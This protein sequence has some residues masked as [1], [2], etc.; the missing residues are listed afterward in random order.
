LYESMAVLTPY[1]NPRRGAVALERINAVLPPLY[2]TWALPLVLVAA[3]VTPSRP[4]A[5]SDTPAEPTSARTPLH[6]A[7]DSLAAIVFGCALI[8]FAIRARVGLT[9]LEFGDETQNY[10]AAVMIRHGLRLYKDILLNH[11]PLED[12]LA[13]L[14]SYVT[15]TQDF[16]R[17]R[18]IVVA[19]ALAACLAVATSPALGRGYTARLWAAALFLAP[20]SALWFVHPLHMLIYHALTG[21][22]AT[23]LLAQ[24]VLPAIAGVRIGTMGAFISGASGV[25]AVT[26]TYPMVVPVGLCVAAAAVALSAYDGWPAVRRMF[27]ALAAGGVTAAL[28]VALWITLYA[29][30]VGLFVYHIYFN[31]FVYAHIVGYSPRDAFRAI[32]FSFTPAMRAHSFAVCLGALGLLGAWRRH[33]SGRAGRAIGLGLTVAAILMLNP[34]GSPDFPDVA[35]MIACFGLM[36]VALGARLGE[37]HGVRLVGAVVAALAVVVAG[38]AVAHTALISPHGML[39]SKAPIAILRPNP[40][41][42]IVA[43]IQR[44]VH[45]GETILALPFMPAYYIQA[46]RLPASPDIYYLPFQ[47]EYDR[48]PILGRVVDLCGDIGRVRPPVILLMEVP[49]GIWGPPS[50]YKPCLPE[51]LARDYTPLPNIPYFFVRRD[52]FP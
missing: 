44:L 14:V 40:R 33:A 30:W 19:L 9:A 15:G 25:L 43:E 1:L 18:L 5:F 36:A 3:V 17:A 52:R 11:G 4:V 10:V 35:Q 31:T 37:T 20:L 21:Y 22:L 24:L 32:I 51:V 26:S 23:I 2:Q 48:A 42:P 6:K 16:S 13:W 34:T 41:D 27:L 46:Q 29:D 12:L 50:Q 7:T 49:M 38:E 8:M 47:A 28:P 45:P 39:R